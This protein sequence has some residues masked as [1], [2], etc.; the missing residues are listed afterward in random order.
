MMDFNESVYTMCE[1]P[2][3]AFFT[4]NTSSFDEVYENLKPCKLLRIPRPMLYVWA[5]AKARENSC[6]RKI[7]NRM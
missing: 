7:F 3:Y 2:K 4:M 5:A 1:D 6:Y